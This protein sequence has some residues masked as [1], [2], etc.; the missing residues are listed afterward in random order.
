M[1]AIAPKRSSYYGLM[2]EIVEFFRTRKAPVPIDETIEMM[3]FMEAADL[4]KSRE[5]AAVRIA[6][7][8]R[9]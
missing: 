3:A 5:G 4:S 2:T 7:V 8:M 6:D 9:K 1:S